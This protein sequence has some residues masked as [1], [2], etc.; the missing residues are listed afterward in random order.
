MQRYIMVGVVGI[1]GAVLLIWILAFASPYQLHGSEITT[2]V[3]APDIELDRADGSQFSL[4]ALEGK[5]VLIFFGYTSC[6]DVCPTTLAEMKRVKTELGD[7][8]SRVVFVFITVDPQRDTPERAQ[9]YAGGF[10]QAFIGLSGSESDLEPVWQGYGVYRKIQDSESA[11]GYLVDHSARVYLVDTAGNLRVT[12][13]YGTPVDDL[14]GDVRFLL[15]ETG[16]ESG[17]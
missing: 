7:L 15:Q 4:K 12:Y 5:V 11:A 10:N 9:A 6:P 14:V 17:R 13:A 3:K 8:D 2:Q 16:D 1:L